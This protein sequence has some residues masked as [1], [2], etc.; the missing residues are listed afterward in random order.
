MG[1]LSGT[2]EFE[3]FFGLKHYSIDLLGISDFPTVSNLPKN[4]Y[5][6]V[7]KNRPPNP[8]ESYLSKCYISNE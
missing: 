3:N 5:W 2:L 7:K 8:P 1:N 4:L 6:S